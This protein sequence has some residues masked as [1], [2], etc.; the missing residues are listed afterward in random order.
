MNSKDRLIYVL[1][2]VSAIGLMPF[3]QWGVLAKYG[4][5]FFFVFTMFYLFL[6][7]AA[8]LS[9]PVLLVRVCFKRY[10]TRALPWLLLALFYLPCYVVGSYL[11]DQVWVSGWEAFT[12][13]SLPLTQAIKAYER[14]HSAPPKRLDDL[15][16]DYLSV[17]PDT[18]IRACPE[19]HYHSDSPTR[20]EYDGNP[21]AISVWTPCIGVGFDQMLY[22]PKQ[23]YPKRGYGGW[24]EPVK[25]WAYVHE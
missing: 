19:F 5:G 6:F 22:F 15:V 14:D 2:A 1:Y 12:E 10:R 17:V 3:A 25:D 7:L 8:V 9:L 4:S 23:N 21:W 11:E 20:N 24:L 18:G 16:P 13:R